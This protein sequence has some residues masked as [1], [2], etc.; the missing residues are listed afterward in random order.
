MPQ[1][2]STSIDTLIDVAARLHEIAHR[3][4]ATTVSVKTQD[5]RR[6]VD[7]VYALGVVV[8]GQ[9]HASAVTAPSG[10]TEA[11]ERLLK[12]FQV[13]EA[14][15]ATTECDEAFAERYQADPQDPMVSHDL[16]IWR[17]AWAARRSPDIAAMEQQIEALGQTLGEC[18]VESGMISPNAGLSGPQLIQFG[19]ELRQHIARMNQGEACN[20]A[21]IDFVLSQRAECELEFLRAWREGNFKA[22]REE[23]PEAPDEVYIGADQFHPKT[24]GY[25]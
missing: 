24:V 20:K 10:V 5:L 17:D 21:V 11:F 9:G 18:I 14:S 3:D 1:N 15:S 6:L 16:S 25:S 22:C 23:W 13:D 12:L 19:T 7:T 2:S 8:V 4:T